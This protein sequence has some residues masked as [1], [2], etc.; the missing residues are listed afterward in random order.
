MSA[1]LARHFFPD[2]RVTADSLDVHAVEGQSRDF[3][4]LVVAGNAVFVRGPAREGRD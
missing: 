2:M 4:L 1:K 3:E